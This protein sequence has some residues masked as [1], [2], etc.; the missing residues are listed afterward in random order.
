MAWVQVIDQTGLDS[1]ISSWL[2][3][4]IF[5]IKAM[6]DVAMKFRKQFKMSYST[7]LTPRK[8]IL[9]PFGPGDSQ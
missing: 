9:N 2:I 1:E 3:Q 4:F 8:A 5:V 7:F 6:K